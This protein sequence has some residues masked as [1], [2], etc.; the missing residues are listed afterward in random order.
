MDFEINGRNFNVDNMSQEDADKLRFLVKNNVIDANEI[1]SAD[2][3]ATG[4]QLNL[5][6]LIKKFDDMSDEEI[7]QFVADQDNK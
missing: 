5:S 4:D 2:E 3:Q 6:S 1:N 7:R